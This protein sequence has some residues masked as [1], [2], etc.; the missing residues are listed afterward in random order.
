MLRKMRIK[1]RSEN[2][3]RLIDKYGEGRLNVGVDGEEFLY[4][5]SEGQEYIAYENGDIAEL[6]QEDRKT[7][8]FAE[9]WGWGNDKGEGYSIG[10]EYQSPIEA[11]QSDGLT[12]II[13]ISTD[14]SVLGYKE[15]GSAIVVCDSHGPWAVDVTDY[16]E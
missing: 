6:Y 4:F 13:Q 1:M 12:C 16:M 3:Q 8:N 15:D 2:F 7:D 14:G 5:F 11:A 10:E 9:A